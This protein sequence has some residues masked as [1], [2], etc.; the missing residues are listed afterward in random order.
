MKIITIANRKGGVGK[1]TVTF[2]LGFT[3][4]LQ[5]KR[6]LFIDLDSQANL[7]MLCNVD[8]VS[9]EE[10]EGF[11][12]ESLNGFIDILPATKRFSVIENQIQE[13][14][15]RNTYLKEAIISKAQGYDYILIDTPPSLNILN[16]NA[17]CVSDL[18]HIVINPDYFSLEGLVEMKRILEQIQ[19]INPKLK[20]KITVNGYEKN[21]KFTDAVMDHLGQDVNYTGIQIPRRQHIIE[22][23]ARREP[24]IRE[25]DI[26]KP[27][28][29]MAAVI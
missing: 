14:I 18:V 11:K 16:I 6:M 17:F 22:C 9:T 5:K 4:A 15:D 19:E 12:I 20:H 7:S 23:S 2:N 28:A 8:P 13:R 3:Y 25:S 27:F 29:A 21:R 10:F 26:Y 1:S 24:A